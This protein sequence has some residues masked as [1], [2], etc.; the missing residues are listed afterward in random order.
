MADRSG[1]EGTGASRLGLG[2]PDPTC[3]SPVAI[4]ANPMANRWS[5]ISQALVEPL[6]VVKNKIFTQPLMQFAYAPIITQVD[7]FILDASP[8]SLHKKVIKG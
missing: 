2:R 6:F 8:K 1:A 4:L 5:F 3:Y 7:V